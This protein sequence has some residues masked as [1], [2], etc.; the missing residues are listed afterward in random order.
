VPL[1]THDYN[2]LSSGKRDKPDAAYKQ[3]LR[4]EDRRISFSASFERFCEFT[5]NGAPPAGTVT[6]TGGLA[7]LRK[8][9]E[10]AGGTM[11]IRSTPD[12]ALMITLPEER[13]NYGI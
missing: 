12:F 2:A 1:I 7:D 11:C 5:N 8:Q 9:I 6:E 3:K 10:N 13:E 4:A